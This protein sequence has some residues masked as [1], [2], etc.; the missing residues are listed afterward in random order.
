SN[1]GKLAVAFEPNVGQT[2]EQ[3]RFLSRGPGFGLFLTDDGATLTLPRSG[4]S[5]VRDVLRLRLDGANP[6]PRIEGVGEQTSRSDYYGALQHTNV[7]RYDRVIYHDVWPGIDWVLYTTP[8]RRLEYDF[9]VR[10]GASPDAIHLSWEGIQSQS[11]D[12]A[13]NL[14]V[15]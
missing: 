6:H 7:Q 3:V 12:N 10:G 9:E 1:F 13:G 15:Q 8:E 5:D 11:L 14:V 2:S 4:Q